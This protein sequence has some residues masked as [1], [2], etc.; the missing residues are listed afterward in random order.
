LAALSADTRENELKVKEFRRRIITLENEVDSIRIDAESSVASMQSNLNAANDQ[1]AVLKKK[2]AKSKIFEKEHE[3]QLESKSLVA[4][5]TQKLKEAGQK[6]TASAS[7]V[8]TLRAEMLE[9]TR[10]MEGDVAVLRKNHALID[11]IA[12]A[13]AEQR[14]I[15]QKENQDLQNEISELKAL[16]Q[17]ETDIKVAEEDEKVIIEQIIKEQTLS[18]SLEIKRLETVC[19][20]LNNE[21]AKKEK[22][23]MTLRD[24]GLDKME[25][26]HDRLKLSNQDQISELEKNMR[27]QTVIDGLREDVTQSKA[28]TDDL[29]CASLAEAQIHEDLEKK[30]NEEVDMLKAC[31][32][33]ANFQIVQLTDEKNEEPDIELNNSISLINSESKLINSETA[34]AALLIEIKQLQCNEADMKSEIAYFTEEVS[35]LT[36]KLTGRDE[37]LFSLES[38]LDKSSMK[39]QALTKRLL[40]LEK[41][42]LVLD[43]PIVKAKEKDDSRMIVR[44]SEDDSSIVRKSLTSLKSKR[45]PQKETELNSKST[46]DSLS[47]KDIEFMTKIFQLE[48]RAEEEKKTFSDRFEMLIKI[49]GLNTVGVTGFDFSEES[50]KDLF[51][52]RSDMERVIIMTLKNCLLRFSD[53]L[54]DEENN[55]LEDL[56]IILSPEV[57]KTVVGLKSALCFL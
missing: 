25:S 23:I 51:R 17:K 27:L 35:Y 45:K 43:V 33:A 30:L 49:A 44:L 15:L 22:E 10:K 21:V 34:S 6:E 7:E 55:D 3:Q 36:E 38:A 28:E 20:D 12:E 53:R 29:K 40:E 24:A 8:I 13:A 4:S 39:E 31:L 26:L 18:V 50:C 48:E 19:A 52:R 42:L 14:S 32:D 1:I 47:D 2:S 16:Q 9:R 54:T 56:G 41:R 57:K 37:E 46:T 11:A 5:L